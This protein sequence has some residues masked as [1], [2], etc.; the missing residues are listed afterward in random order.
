M[1]NKLIADRYITLPGFDQS[2]PPAVANFPTDF[3]PV[4]SRTYNIQESTTSGSIFSGNRITTSQ[5][6]TGAHAVKTHRTFRWLPW[7]LGKVSCCDLSGVDILTGTMSGCWLVVFSY[8][9]KTYAG[10]IGT[11]TDPNT[12]NTKQAKAAWRNAVN[13]GQ[14]VPIAAFNPVAVPAANL[15]I[16]NE[17]PEFYGGFASNG[18]VYTIVLTIDKLGGNKRRIAKVLKINPGPDVTAF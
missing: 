12:D 9:G 11:D 1:I 14:I 15:N 6:A 18:E 2:P 10:H 16:K 7:V 5:I 4:S 13:N 3:A 8:N 17:A